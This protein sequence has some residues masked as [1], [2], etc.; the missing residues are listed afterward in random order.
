MFQ[1][2]NLKQIMLTALTFGVVLYIY[3]SS[4]VSQEM[5]IANNNGNEGGGGNDSGGLEIPP[6]PTTIDQFL[7]LIRGSDTQSGETRNS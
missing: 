6:P 1:A 2:K 5:M 7:K 4:H 3:A